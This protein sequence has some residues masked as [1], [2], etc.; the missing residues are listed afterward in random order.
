MLLI[1]LHNNRGRDNAPYLGVI[2]VPGSLHL[3]E[4]LYMENINS[5]FVN[6]SQ[7]EADYHFYN[8]STE[9]TMYNE[10]LLFY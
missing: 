5:F 8:L 6:K 2:S 1:Y 10:N 7:I 4:D 3:F 9:W